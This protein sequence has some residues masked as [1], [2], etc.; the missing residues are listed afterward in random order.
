[1]ADRY[2]YLPSIGLFIMFA[3]SL[4][5]L[6]GSPTSRG[7]VTAFSVAAVAACAVLTHAQVQV[8]RD[9][10]TLFNDTLSKTADNVYIEFLLGLEL[11]EQRRT[12]EALPHL[13]RYF[14]FAP[15]NAPLLVRY[16]EAMGACGQFRKAFVL[17]RRGFALDPNFPPQSL[18]N[19][20]CVLA[21]SPDASMR[22]GALAVRLASKACELTAWS[23]PRCMF[24]LAAAQAETGAF[25]DAIDTAQ[26]ASTMAK[27]GN[28]LPLAAAIDQATEMFRKNE[29][30]RTLPLESP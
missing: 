2:L 16:A 29:P 30:L 25:D 21:T 22:D 1:M 19:F 24:N 14:D 10:I 9:S 15:D 12:S 23:D 13:Q 27:A 11:Q 7:I 3:W 18:S 20:A 8:W 26:R 17:Y 28:Q 6:T 4:A 5:A